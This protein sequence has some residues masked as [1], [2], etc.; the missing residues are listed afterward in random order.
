VIGRRLLSANDPTLWQ[1]A[2]D[3]LFG[4]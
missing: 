4:E 3:A 1:T 2:R